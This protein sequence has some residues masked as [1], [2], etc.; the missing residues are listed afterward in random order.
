MRADLDNPIWAALS[1]KNAD[2]GLGNERAKLF[3]AEVAPFAGLSTY[4]PE[5]FQ[6][7]Y[8]LP[9]PGQVVVLF[10]PGAELD[11]HPFELVVKVPGYQ[12]VFEGAEPP[13]E[14]DLTRLTEQVVPD[15]L[16]LT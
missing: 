1:S 5:N 16:A 6:E 9:E 8:Q 10:F 15:M 4:S 13:L 12:M 2:L 14:H 11:I 7:L 3:N